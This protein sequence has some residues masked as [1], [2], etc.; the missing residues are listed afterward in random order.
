MPLSIV[1]S[2]L[3]RFLIQFALFAAVWIYH[4]A[5]DNS[6]IEP[7]AYAALTPILLLIM[8]L[9]SLGLGM[10]LSSL[11]TKYRDLGML[12]GFGMQLFMYATPIIYPLSEVPEKYKFILLAN[13]ITSIVE[14]FRYGFLGTGTFNWWYLTYSALASIIILLLGT[15]IFNKV[16][17]SFMDTV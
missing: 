9:L 3:V 4:L 16:E 17:K 6:V 14:T 15:I 13:P 8:A 5:K 12:M 1:I 11:T 2:N 7:N 10:I